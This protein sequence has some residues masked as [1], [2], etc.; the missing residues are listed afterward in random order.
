MKQVKCL[1]GGK[2]VQYVD[3]HMADS[4]GTPESKPHGGLNY[5]YGVFPLGFLWPIIVIV[6]FTVKFGISQDPPMC[7][8]PSLSQV[9]FY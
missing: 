9:E 8:H 2:S 1:L 3:R 5:F 4:E 7:A 6:W